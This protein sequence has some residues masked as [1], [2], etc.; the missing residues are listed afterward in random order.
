MDC[1]VLPSS[2]QTALAKQRAPAV[3]ELAFPR[4]NAVRRGRWCGAC[5]GVAIT[6]RRITPRREDTGGC[7][8]LARVLQVEIGTRSGRDNEP[9]CGQFVLSLLSTQRDLEVPICTRY[10]VKL[11]AD[12]NGLM[13]YSDSSVP[14]CGTDLDLLLSASPAPSEGVPRGA[15]RG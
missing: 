6:Q 11:I 12:I 5:T 15:E 2:L 1:E 3:L 14:A 4:T 8:G 7:W 9:S 10:Y 13:R